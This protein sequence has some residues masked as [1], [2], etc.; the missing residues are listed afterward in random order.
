VTTHSETPR[1]DELQ[2]ALDRGDL[3]CVR[4]LLL[5]LDGEEERLLT[6]EMGAAALARARGAAARGRRRGKLGKVLVL[7]G[8]MG[9]ELDSVDRKGD[10]D[11]IWINFARL[12]GGRIGD[13]E[14]TSEGDPARAGFHVRPAGVHR[15]TYI[16]LLME[17]DARWHVRPF[18]FD[19]REDLDRSAARLDAEVKAFGAGDP[20][21]LVAHSMGGLVSRRFAQ[22]FPETWRAMDDANGAGRGGRLIMLGTPNRGSFSI[23]LTLSGA[24]K[25]VQLLAKAD[26]HHSLG[27]LL[28]IVG[29]FPGMYQMLPSPVV[30]LDDDHVKLFDA[31]SWGKLPARA[32]LLARAKKVLAELDGVIDAHR[33]VYVAGVNRETP[34]R[35]RIDSAGKFSY[36]QTLDGDG[37]VPHELGLLAGVPTYWVDEVHGDLAKNG[38]VLDA[39]TELLHTGKTSVLT[40]TQTATA[41]ARRATRGWQSGAAVAPLSP[42]VDLILG[43]AKAR[44]RAGTGA[45]LS[46]EDEVRLENLAFAELLGSGEPAE[47]VRSPERAA[48]RDGGGDGSGDGDG[49]GPGRDGPAEPTAPVAVEVVWGDVTK[50]D[51]ADVYAVGHYEGVLPQRAELALDEAVSGVRGKRQYDRRQ[52]LITQ[53]TQRGALHAALGDLSYFPWHDETRSGRVVAVAGMGRPGTFDAAGLRRI[54]SGLLLA[55]SA[56]PGAETLCTVLIGSGEGTLTIEQSARAYV[57]GISDAV[58]EIASGGAFRA[59]VKALVV[60]ERDR[61]RAEE[62]LEALKTELARVSDAPDADPVPIRLSPRLKRAAGGSVSVEEGVALVAETL[63]GAAVAARGSREARALQTLMEQSGPNQ[64]V[65]SL[66]LEQLREEGHESATSPRPRFRVERRTAEWRGAAIPARI[67]FWD[68]GTVIRAAAIH[69]AATVPERLVAVGRDVVD[70]LVAK[71]TDPAADEVD[72]LCDLLYRLLVPAEFG[73]VLSSGSLVF[74]V[75]RPMARLHWEMLVSE[76]TDSVPFAVRRPFARQLRTT[77]SPAPLR[78]G[79]GNEPFR[80]LIVGDPGDP[81]NGEDLPG[82]RREALVVKALLEARGDIVVETRIGAPSVAREGDLQGIRAADRLEVLSLLLRGRFDLVHY[83]GHGD[84]DP[85]QPNRVG[86]L[87]ANGLLTPGEIGRLQ[88]VPAVIV[89]NACLSARTSLTLEGGRRQDEARSEAGLLPSLA[90]EFFKLGVRN[91]VGTAWEVN[92]VGAELFAQVFYGALL[93]GESFGEAV[94]SARETLWR[95]NETFGALWAAYQHYGDPS[96]SPGL[97]AVSDNGA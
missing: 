7:P 49:A 25:V 87:F 40:T 34:A 37:R 62:I 20:V 1:I 57:E 75:D 13:L 11:R 47:I 81:A 68:D 97:A 31:K 39:I 53:R 86:W 36:R 10:V 3:D 72:D 64:T 17:L 70:D 28:S 96:S 4:R 8:I 16:P 74:E 91:Y 67:S 78:R 19:W 85:A 41:P 26:L 82:A 59:P 80:A 15:K 22:L 35:I 18:P 71:M 50:F 30:D 21:H 2:D 54:V 32:P 83:A 58:E 94:R 84:F 24:E 5:Q 77:Y 51:K 45:E 69:E 44:S 76:D 65:R 27:E 55:V 73:D 56:L 60:A 9:T 89:S 42:E 23:P 93:D 48:A 52:L 66:A 43:K 79:R 90:D 63:L 29:T 12:I 33:L 61:G 14:L 46:R 38:Q 92:D 88:R 95:D 6:E